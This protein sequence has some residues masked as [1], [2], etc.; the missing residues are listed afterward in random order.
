MVFRYIP[1]TEADIKEMLDSIGA[2]GMDELFQNIPAKARLNRELHI[3]PAMT[4]DAL[5]KHMKGLA[6]KN[7]STEEYATFLGAGAYDH[8]IP[9]LVKH[10][11]FRSEFYTA[12]TP[13]QPEISQ[14]ILQ[15]IYEYQTMISQLTGLEVVNAS[16]YDG[17]TA[18]A[19]AAT[20]A[21]ASTRR[22]K[23][24]VSETVHPESF[25]II[26][27]YCKG[28]G[29][30]VEE[31]PQRLGIIDMEALSSMITDEIAAVCVQCPNFFG[32]IEDLQRIAELTHQRKGLFV[33]SV[34]P[35]ALGVLKSPGELGADIVVGEGQPLGNSLSF[36]G[37]Y[38]GFFATTKA[39]MRK[40][41]GRIVGQTVDGE[42][43]RGFALTLQARE[44]HIRREKATS[45]ICSNQALNALVATIYLATIGKQ[46]LVELA[47][48]N[49]QKAHYLYNKLSQLEGVEIPFKNP[50][51]NEFAIKL[52]VEI[53]TVN[54]ELYK[55]KMIGGYDLGKVDVQLEKHMLIAVTEKRTK[56]ELDDFVKVLE[57]II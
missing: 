52:P 48:A 38:L 15:A 2:E 36:G 28:Q 7:A 13:Y 51:F 16:M 22:K 21:A 45:N 41:P 4:E 27:N 53:S 19:E 50:F 46:G 44:Q 8:Y 31:I 33:V 55:Y 12:Y 20:M 32:S 17:Q 23:V 57:G 56:E 30:E 29:I 37:P 43:R 25:E 9:S 26:N 6:S 3:T 24:L 34:N 40:I 54:A 11:V 49:V 35:I 1:N 10:L 47:Q 5:V 42:G 39:L 18:F 14:G